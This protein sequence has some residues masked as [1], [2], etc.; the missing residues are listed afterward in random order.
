LVRIGKTV[1][2]EARGIAE[3]TEG[4]VIYISPIVDRDTHKVHVVAE[5]DNKDGIWRPGSFLTAA[6]VF[7]EQSVPIAV[8]VSAVQTMD[9]GTVA[10]VRT[11]KGFQKRQ[12]VLGQDDDRAAEV[13]FGLHLGETIAVSNTFLL[14]AEMLKG[15]GEE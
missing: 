4:Q 3:K 1:L 11:A 10:F 14:K 2:V 5:I 15:A 6:I 12:V 7:E 9:G 8:P 13:V